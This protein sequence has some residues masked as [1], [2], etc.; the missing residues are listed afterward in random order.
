MMRKKNKTSDGRS[1]NPLLSWSVV[2]AV[3]DKIDGSAGPLLAMSVPG[4]PTYRRSLFLLFY[5]LFIFCFIF[6]CFSVRL[7]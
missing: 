4:L 5:L 7:F 6:L 1:N 3:A 2:G